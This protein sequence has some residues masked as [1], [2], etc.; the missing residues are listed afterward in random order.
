[1]RLTHPVLRLLSTADDY[2]AWIV[3]VLPVI[4]GLAATS[5][6]GARYE[7]LLAVHILSVALLLAWL[8]YGKLMHPFFVFITRGFTGV[9]LSRRGAEL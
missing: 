9:Y 4:T 3:T 2:F 8:P 6:L 7:T 1:R 5:H